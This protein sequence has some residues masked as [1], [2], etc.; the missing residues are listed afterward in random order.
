MV[1]GA[2]LVWVFRCAVFE[3]LGLMWV[4]C[5]LVWVLGVVFL[6]CGAYGVCCFLV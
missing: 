1:C 2:F 6:K 4:C 3:V 5:F